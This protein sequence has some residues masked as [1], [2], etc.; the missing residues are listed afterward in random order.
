MNRLM[1]KTYSNDTHN[2]PLSCYQYDTSSV[3]N[4]G[5]NLVGRLTNEWTQSVSVGA[6]CATTLAAGSYLSLRSILSYDPMGRILGER[7]C[8]QASCTTGVPYNSTASY[9]FLGNLSSL[10]SDVHAIG[11]AQ[12][13]DSA[14]HLQSV[15]S[16]WSDPTHPGNLFTAGSYMPFGAIQ[17]MTLGTNINVT[18]TYDLR[19]R[20]T[21]ESA[22]QQ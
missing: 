4:S 16:S 15:V 13:Y 7:Q 17:S 19:L 14:G 3:P 1:S 18:K 9:N 20:V 6:T 2:T 22:G 5:G 11:L 8:H 12:T 21:G 10:L